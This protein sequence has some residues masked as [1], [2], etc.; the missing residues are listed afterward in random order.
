MRD[1]QS[2]EKIQYLYEHPGQVDLNLKGIS[3]ADPS[4]SY[5]VVQQDIPALR[6]AQANKNVF[7]FNSTFM[8]QLQNMSDECGFT[9]YLDECAMALFTYCAL[10]KERLAS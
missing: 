5:D 4:L 3:I 8:A 9:D 1:E 6:F 10:S 2:V 7:P